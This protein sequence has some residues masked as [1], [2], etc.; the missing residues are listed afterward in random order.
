L[1]DDGEEDKKNRD[2]EVVVKKP[3][4]DGVNPRKKTVALYRG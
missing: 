4:N 1:E 2:L 3:V